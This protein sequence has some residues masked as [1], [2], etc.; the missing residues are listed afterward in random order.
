MDMADQAMHTST[1]SVVRPLVFFPSHFLT[2]TLAVILLILG[3]NHGLYC[4]K[5]IGFQCNT[6]S[7]YSYI[8]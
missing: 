7:S 8:M 5:T 3:S 1:L 6:S 2:A 4:H